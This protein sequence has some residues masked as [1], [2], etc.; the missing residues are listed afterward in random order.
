MRNAEG[1]V[2]IHVTY[3]GTD[4]GGIRD[5]DLRVEV[6]TIHV[7]LT[8]MR[9]HDFADF[10]DRL[11]KYAVCRRIGDHQRGEIF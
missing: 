5:P 11:F 9:M 4:F 10:L 8:T 1:F 7:N 6:R 2:Q 3:V